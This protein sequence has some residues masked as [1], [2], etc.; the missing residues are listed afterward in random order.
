MVTVH[1]HGNQQT[2]LR[3]YPNLVDKLRILH[4]WV[5]VG[6]HETND[7]RVDFRKKW[8]IQ[9]KYVAVFAGV[10]GPS[11][12]LELVLHVAEKMSDQSELL[13]LLVGNGKEKEKLQ[14]LALEKSLNNVCF[15]GFVSREVYPDLLRICSIGLICLSP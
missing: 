10:I 8:N 3:Q 11:Q 14:K 6:Y 2:V 12:Y 4:N 5:D 7:I 1:S 9:Q 15:K 13:F